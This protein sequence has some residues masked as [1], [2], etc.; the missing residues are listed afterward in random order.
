MLIC[1]FIHSSVY[2]FYMEM[3]EAGTVPVLACREEE[4]VVFAFK[5]TS[6]FME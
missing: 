5:H 1:S 6:R 3:H 2:K 4:V